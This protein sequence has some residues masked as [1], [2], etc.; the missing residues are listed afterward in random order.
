MSFEIEN[1]H[2]REILDSRGNPTVEVDV[3]TCCGFGRAAVPSGASTGT[4][5]ALELRDGDDRYGGKGVLKAVKN[6]NEIIGPKL[7]ESG[8]SA[9]EQRAVDDFMLA[10]DGTPLKSNL[11]ANAI[12]GVSLAVA[13]AAAR[14]LGIPLYHYLGGVNT[15][16]LPVPSLNVLNGGQHAGNDLAIQEFMILPKGAS[17][18][19][20]GL[21][22][23]AE[24]YHALGKILSGRYG[25][26][27]TNVGYE[28]GY[29]PPLNKTCDALDALMSALDVTGYDKEIGIGMDAAASSFFANGSYAIDSKN[30]S[31]GE[32]VDFYADL[33]ATYP[34]ILI[35]DPFEEEA[36]E[37]FAALTARLPGTIIVGDDIYVTNV[38]RLAKG[39]EMKAT[40]ALL[41]KLNQIG[42]VSEA[43]DAARMA[44]RNGFKVMASHRSAETEDSALADVTVALGAEMLKTG[45]PARSERNAKYNQLLRIE[46]ELGFAASYAKI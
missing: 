14:E 1:V 41:L 11:G 24:T 46:E 36:Y 22:M 9:L 18:F 10:L 40:N 20:E 13:K 8:I 6:V 17:C 28:G 27:A 7:I 4:H 37:D 33:V 12:L 32:M 35:E 5:E 2:A 23:A 44:F 29:A 43:F 19:S 38:E 16:T 25:A 39:I 21:R 34:I 3:L 42:S 45:A 26:G 15:T 30:L 31:S